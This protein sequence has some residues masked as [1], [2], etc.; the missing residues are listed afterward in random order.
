MSKSWRAG[1]TEAGISGLGYV[2]TA[3]H[4]A[5]CA[6]YILSPDVVQR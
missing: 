1:R 6:I 3:V 2:V 5:V 4:G